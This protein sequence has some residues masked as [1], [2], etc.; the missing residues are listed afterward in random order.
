MRDCPINKSDWD[1]ASHELQCVSPN[2]YHCML[3]E[4]GEPVK[5]CLGKIW[6]QE[7]FCPEYNSNVGRI[8]VRPCSHDAGCPEKTYWSNEVYRYSTCIKREET[9]GIYYITTTLSSSSSSPGDDSHLSPT[10]IAIIVIVLTLLILTISVVAIV[11]HRKRRPGQKNQNSEILER[12]SQPENEEQEL[13]S[14]GN[15]ASTSERMSHGAELK[16]K[17]SIAHE[18]HSIDHL[19]KDDHGRNQDVEKLKRSGVLIYV[20]STSDTIELPV[21]A[22][23]NQIENSG[24]FGE[25]VF[26]A[27]LGMWEPEQNVSLYI[28]RQPMDQLFSEINI[29]QEKME[30]MYEMTNQSPKTYFVMHFTTD[31]WTKHQS[32]LRKYKLFR[33]E[34]IINI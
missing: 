2:S 21:G 32:T 19:T 13:L 30:E 20:S 10:I 24:K 14:T 29:T 5:Q 3:D 17:S 26:V 27:S 16:T 28:F 4:K 6:I 7:G 12:N 1:V 23:I 34:N 18:P 11:I 9:N 25:S 22:R 31:E 8:D 33:G 15:I